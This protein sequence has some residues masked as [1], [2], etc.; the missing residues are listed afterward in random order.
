M[1][2]FYQLWSS[3]NNYFFSSSPDVIP[4]NNYYGLSAIF[5]IYMKYSDSV[6]C[7]YMFVFEFFAFLNFAY[8]LQF[9]DILPNLKKHAAICIPAVLAP[10]RLCGWFHFNID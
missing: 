2:Y 4:V 8:I 9:F 3:V 7:L 1:L 5:N 10:G 6:G